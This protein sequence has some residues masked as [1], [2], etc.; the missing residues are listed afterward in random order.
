M[1]LR[2]LDLL[3]KSIQKGK[4]SINSC[5]IIIELLTLNDGNNNKRYFNDSVFHR[6]KTRKLQLLLI[7][8]SV[9]YHNCVSSNLFLVR[10]F[11]FVLFPVRY[12]MSL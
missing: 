6:T 12:F 4:N 9:L 2:V 3:L 5:Q 1:R 7:F 11:F 10:M 8:E